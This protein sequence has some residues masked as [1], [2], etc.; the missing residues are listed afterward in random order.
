MLFGLNHAPG[1]WH[2]LGFTALYNTVFYTNLVITTLM[3]YS[4]V[5]AMSVNEYF[6]GDNTDYSWPAIVA[7]LYGSNHSLLLTWE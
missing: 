1:S 5:I 3:I 6:V 7:T 4:N 2:G